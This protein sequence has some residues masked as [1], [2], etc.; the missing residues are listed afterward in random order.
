MGEFN[1][2]LGRFFIIALI[3]LALFNLIISA[4][5]ENNAE[6]KLIDEEVFNSSFNKLLITVDNSTEKSQ[7][8]YDVFI[9]EEPKTGF[10]SLVL[11]G[12]VSVGRTFSNVVF[13]TL[14]AIIRLPLIILGIPEQTLNLVIAW[15]IIVVIVAVWLLYK[16]GG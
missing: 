9:S 11:F 4:Q 7:E 1:K 2:I 3:C 5:E 16:L 6:N 15:L 10:G 12:I 14:S 8:K 13:G